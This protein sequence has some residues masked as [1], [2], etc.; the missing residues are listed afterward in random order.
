MMIS[1]QI[2]LSSAKPKF[3]LRQ[4]RKISAATTAAHP[5]TMSVPGA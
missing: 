1:P 4:A 2:A 3:F 5:L